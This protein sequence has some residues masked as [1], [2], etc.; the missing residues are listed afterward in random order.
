MSIALSGKVDLP[1]IKLGTY[2]F[3]AA[4]LDTALDEKA[5]FDTENPPLP[6]RD[7]GLASNDSGMQLTRGDFDLK[8]GI[9]SLRKKKWVID[10]EAVI[11]LVL[12]EFSPSNLARA[13]WHNLASIKRMIDTPSVP[14]IQQVV[15]SN[16][17]GGTLYTLTG[18]PTSTV[19]DVTSAAGLV[20]GNMIVVAA[21]DPAL[22]TSTNRSFITNIV[23]NTITVSPALPAGAPASGD[24]MR[25]VTTI[26]G[27]D[28]NSASVTV[29]NGAEWTVDQFVALAQTSLAL[30]ASIYEFQIKSIV[31]N[32]LTFDRKIGFAFNPEP[33]I[34]QV[35]S[36]K[37]PFGGGDSCKIA[38]LGVWDDTEGDQMLVYI[39]RA[40]C[41]GDFDINFYASAQNLK[42]AMAVECDEHYMNLLDEDSIQAISGSPTPTATTFTV[43]NGAAFAIGQEVA[44][45]SVEYLLDYTTNKGIIQSIATNAITLTKPLTKV[46]VAGWKIKRVNS[47][48][49]NLV[50]MLHFQNA[51]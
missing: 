11:N 13:T 33:F 37:I 25:T 7:L 30:P 42:F 12:E 31:G 41:K 39:P 19:F 47:S 45:E 35:Y 21:T 34:G 2:R 5:V 3:F 50:S 22:N 44:V 14:A 8:A 51:F 48:V 23:S 28:A 40:T 49:G 36:F 43:S 38:L 26:N 9:P 29:T 17:L 6:W 27:G 4:P 32:V 10:R 46:P 24:K 16:T 1:Y 15:A 18:S 20:I